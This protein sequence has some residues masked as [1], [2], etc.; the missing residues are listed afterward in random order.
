M[1]TAK[2]QIRYS[3]LSCGSSDTVSDFNC[4]LI[5]LSIMKW[6]IES[7]Q[8]LL[9]LYVEVKTRFDK[10][11]E[12]D[13]EW[14][15][16]MAEKLKESDVEA[17]WKQVKDKVAAIKKTG[18]KK[19]KEF[20]LPIINKKDKTG[21]A[22]DGDEDFN[23]EI[24]WEDVLRKAK[25]PLLRIY[26]EMFRD[27]P[28]MGLQFGNDT[29]DSDSADS[30]AADGEAEERV[31]CVVVPNDTDSESPASNAG[32]F[33]LDEDEDLTSADEDFP[34]VPLQPAALREAQRAALP[35]AQPAAQ[36]AAQPAA[37]RADLLAAQP[38]AQAAALPPAQ[39]AR[40]QQVAA[41][42]AGDEAVHQE[43]TPGRAAA[44]TL[45][46]RIVPRTPARAT[47][48]QQQQQ[49][50]AGFADIVQA[51]T[52]QNLAIQSQLQQQQQDFEARQRQRDEERANAS[53]NRQEQFQ[54]NV[55]Q[56]LMTFQAT[57]MN[58][59]FGGNRRRRRESDSEED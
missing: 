14:Y 43:V 17:T 9:Q 30:D 12:R 32:G 34:A 53:Q 18:N 57:L 24:N 5:S 36:R 1:E 38:A 13:T 48:Q 19:V 55:Q 45:P 10:R 50:L 44:R 6:T 54:L 37:Q 47:H 31:E 22:T 7:E 4:C 59:M 42:A 56:S 3:I 41:A 26:F 23:D 29:A 8:L 21:A 20:V 49:F 2:I 40:A 16:W 35:V 46:S 58:N 11:M 51:Q 15:R 52:Q 25:W 27:H 39:P 33:E 28:T